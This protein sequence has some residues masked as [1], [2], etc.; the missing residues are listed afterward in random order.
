MNYCN[1]N[2]AWMEFD[3]PPL[4]SKKDLHEAFNDFSTQ[5]TCEQFMQHVKQC[6]YCKNKLKIMYCKENNVNTESFHNIV[7]KIHSEYIRPIIP[8]HKINPEIKEQ[9]QI[10]LL[11]LAFILIVLLILK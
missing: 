2:E 7:K 4:T 1:I 11:I 6:K 8:I 5:I 10:C 9:L 3:V